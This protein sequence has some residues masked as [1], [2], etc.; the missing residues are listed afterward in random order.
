MLSP[1]KN[2]KYRVILSNGEKIDFGD[3][4]YAQYKD[5]M[6]LKAYQHLDH[7]DRD[8][9]ARYYARH[10]IDYPEFTPDWLSKRYLW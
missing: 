2:K 6:P 4:R 3:S 7:N 8:R 1:K 10:K 9:R 5:R